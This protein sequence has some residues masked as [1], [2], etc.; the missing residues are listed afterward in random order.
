M[1]SY[2]GNSLIM[3]IFL[4]LTSLPL[5]LLLL[6]PPSLAVETWEE[7]QPSPSQGYSC[8]EMDV[9]FQGYDIDL[10][11]SVTEWRVCGTICNIT[12]ECEF[13]TF[14]PLPGYQTCLLK[15]ADTGHRTMEGF[16]SGQ[17]GCL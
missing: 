10:I 4:T 8:P 13:W 9:D 1:G 2:R 11:Q 15:S 16:I 17:K 6:C 3:K 12:P 14:N 5:L 7:T